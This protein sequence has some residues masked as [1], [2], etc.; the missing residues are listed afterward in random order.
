MWGRL[1]W[2]AEKRRRAEA[3]C[4]RHPDQPTPDAMQPLD[5]S[6]NH[7]ASGGSIRPFYSWKYE[8]LKDAGASVMEMGVVKVP[9]ARTATL[10][11]EEA[12][13]VHLVG[14]HTDTH[15]HFLW[16]S[17]RTGVHEHVDGKCCR[18]VIRGS[19]DFNDGV[20]GSP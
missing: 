10:H 3:T 2:E 17:M 12:K 19:S 14:C 16:S 15:I 8:I 6:Q 18:L 11:F 9:L 4:L 20:S 5:T 7:G 1:V 13:K